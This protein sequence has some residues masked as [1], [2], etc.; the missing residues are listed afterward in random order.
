MKKKL[1]IT[2]AIFGLAPGVVLAADDTL[3]PWHDGLIPWL[4]QC[5]QDIQHMCTVN[6]AFAAAARAINL[7]IYMAGIFATYLLVKGGYD[8]L[9]AGLQGDSK[10]YENGKSTIRN[11][12]VGMA[13]IFS[14]FVVVNS[15]MVWIF[16]VNFS[17]I[18]F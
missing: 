6:D 18:N 2:V 12:A 5:G 14:A 4:L 15:I 11:V 8:M 1:L 3:S 17:S 13:I 7:A 10:M 9:R 16:G